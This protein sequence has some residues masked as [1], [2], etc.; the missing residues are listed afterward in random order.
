MQWI[1]WIGVI[2]REKITRNM[3]YVNYL[4]LLVICGSC[5]NESKESELPDVFI[6]FENGS[7]INLKEVEANT[8]LILFQT[9]CDHCQREATAIQ[10]NLKSFE[11][12]GVFFVAA[13]SYM[14][15]KT[16]AKHYKLEGYSNIY[17]GQLSGQ[18]IYETFGSIDAPSIYIYREGTLI[19]HFNGETPVEQI[20]E[21]L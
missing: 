3:K 19:H 14:A 18:V 7:K 21:K 10:Q 8:V 5:S 11:N 16:F 6:T 4:V 15:I 17:F 12:Y 9:G 13:D 2:N 20:I 1:G